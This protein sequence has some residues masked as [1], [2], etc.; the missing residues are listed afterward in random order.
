MAK[1]TADEGLDGPHTQRA[2]GDRRLLSPR[3]V[4]VLVDRVSLR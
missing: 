4:T 1:P 2:L 3:G